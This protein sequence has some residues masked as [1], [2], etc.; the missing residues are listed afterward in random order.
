VSN[1]GNIALSNVVVTDPTTVVNEVLNGAFNVGD[2]DQDDLLDVNEVWQYTATHTVTQEELNTNGGGDGDIDNVAT[3]D[4]TESGPA[5][6]DASIPVAANPALNI[7]K[8]A[9]PGQI[10]DVAGELL[11][12]SITVQNV[13]NVA[14]TGVVVTDPTAVV[15]PVL[16]G[17]F[18]VGDTD[19]DNQLDLGETWQYTATHTVT[20]QELDNNGGGDGDVDNTATADSNESPPDSDDASVP[21]I[22]NPALNILKTATPGQVADQAGEAI[23]YTITVQN[24]GNLT[25]TGVVVTDPFANTITRIADVTGDND[26]NL[27]VGETWAFSATHIVTQQ[28]LDS[29]GGGDGTLENTATADSNESPPDTDTETVPVDP[30]PTG[31]VAQAT[32]FEAGNERVPPAGDPL[33][34]AVG[35]S[36]AIDGNFANNSSDV[37]NASGS[38]NLT[39]GG[40]GPGSVADRFDWSTTVTADDPETGAPNDVTL[41][42]GGF[43]VTWV[44]TNNG[45]TLS[46][47]IQ[48]GPNNGQVVAILTATPSGNGMNFSYQQ[49]GPFDHPDPGQGG[50]D[51]PIALG[52][53]YT[54]QDSSGTQSPGSLTVTVNDD[55]PAGIQGVNLVDVGIVKDE[56]VQSGA[57]GSNVA[58]VVDVS[59]STTETVNGDT[60]LQVEI[61]AVKEVLQQAVDANVLGPVLIVAFHGNFTG[62]QPPEPRSIFITFASVSDALAGIDAFF[63][64][65]AGPVWPGGTEGSTRWEGG[66]DVAADWFSGTLAQ[67]LP[68][69]D[70]SPVGAGLDPIVQ[71]NDVNLT[72][73][74]LFFVTDGAN[75][76]AAGGFTPNP[77]NLPPGSNEGGIANLYENVG[78]L[79]TDIPN[80]TVRTV[81]IL[82]GDTDG[83]GT[84]DA[85]EFA[86][87]VEQSDDNMINN[88]A[89]II[90]DAA[91]VGGIVGGFGEIPSNNTAEGNL[92]EDDDLIGG[93]GADGIIPV[94]GADGFETNPPS[95]ESFTFLNGSN[96]LQT[97]FVSG[98]Y[99]TFLGGTIE[100]DFATG[101]Y[102]YTAPTGSVTGTDHFTYVLLDGDDDPQNGVLDIEIGAGGTAAENN[103]FETDTLL[104][105]SAAGSVWV[106]DSNGVANTEGDFF[107]ALH[108]GNA[109]VA[110]FPPATVNQLTP[111]EDRNIPTDSQLEG[112][113][114]LAAGSLDALV[115][116][117]I[118]LEGTALEGQFDVATPGG[119]Y[120]VSFDWQFLTDQ[121]VSPGGANDF[122]FVVI[123]GQLFMLANSDNQGTPRAATGDITNVL[124]D[125]QEFALGTTFQED[126]TITVTD[127]G[128]D[129]VINVAFGVVNGNALGSTDLGQAS[130]LIVDDV[131]VTPA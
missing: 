128:N 64:S 97:V 89:T 66:L 105:W 21:I 46:A 48:G 47:T 115:P 70:G 38:L 43:P 41:T 95:L 107:A 52:F 84:D 83:D 58:F 77:A 86:D 88:S 7:I 54:I 99:A 78:A 118:A 102:F 80:L 18:N 98:T 51:D 108:T 22:Q 104:F 19:Q 91:G 96:A 125:G 20:Q 63:A 106:S 17:A 121:V 126:D 100:V 15:N 60:R 29:N 23:T 117:T 50:A 28:E 92:F 109:G 129:G 93:P 34:F 119:Q 44:A 90:N 79:A 3:A 4:S 9:N 82:N 124:F 8:E 122:A 26:A 42:S 36:E 113:L 65:L 6:D 45:E 5:S 32:V 76:N 123:E 24:T 31:G 112:F 120:D 37:E 71:P 74:R 130:A 13:G 114:G 49:I 35:T 27:E 14:L 62:T 1:A 33:I 40:D 67:T 110:G 81:A 10:A 11:T 55:E 68:T 57:T 30:S 111:P 116:S 25:L 131:N 16:N 12:Y 73:N 87:I 85:V 72:D 56:S 101:D 127:V 103:G 53:S 59:N 2:T 61:L 39:F 94:I 69:V 75:N